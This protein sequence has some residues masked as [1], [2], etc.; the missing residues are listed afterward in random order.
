[1]SNDILKIGSKVILKKLSKIDT[2]KALYTND[3][4]LEEYVNVIGV[5]VTMD[6]SLD[7][8]C[9]KFESDGKDWQV[10][11][12]DLDLVFE[13]KGIIETF[14]QDVQEVYYFD[15]TEDG[16]DIC[17]YKN[18]FESIYQDGEWLALHDHDGRI[19]KYVLEN[20]ELL[21]IVNQKEIKSPS[22]NT[23]DDRVGETYTSK[24]DGSIKSDGGSTDYYKRAIPLGMLERWNKD[25]FIEAKDVMKVFLGNDYNFCNSFKA[26]CRIQSLHEGVG[27]EGIDEKY[28][29]KKAS[30]F[31]QDA[32]NH[33]IENN[34]Q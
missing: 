13:H 23:D 10:K 9:V 7:E 27:K 6:H 3:F 12:K 4:H 32:Y 33:Y 5:V 17:G 16:E 18:G 15:D 19:K 31:S 11:I 25:G 20:G 34:P 28:D 8:V 21:F 2:N 14:P 24:P 29:L 30:F 22:L 26:H 1:M